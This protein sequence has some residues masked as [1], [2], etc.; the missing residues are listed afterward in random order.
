MAFQEKTNFFTLVLGKRFRFT[1]RS[2]AQ[3]IG[4]VIHAQYL[5]NY[6]FSKISR[7]IFFYQQ[8]C[9]IFIACFHTIKTLFVAALKNLL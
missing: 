1:G 5:F 8:R 9:A 2:T 6:P 7:N 4:V 3:N